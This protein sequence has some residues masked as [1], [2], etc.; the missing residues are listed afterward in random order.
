MKI[1]TL[2]AQQSSLRIE[3]VRAC[4]NDKDV[5]RHIFTSYVNNDSVNASFL[6][7]EK[8]EICE[9]IVDTG[10]QIGIFNEMIDKTNQEKTRL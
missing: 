8:L 1:G 6:F 10:K 9:R 5:A 7:D 3:L 2:K 4:S